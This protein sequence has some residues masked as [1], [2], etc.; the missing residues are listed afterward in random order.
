[1]YPRLLYAFLDVVCYVTNNF[2]YE[3]STVK[4]YPTSFRHR[5]NILWNNRRHE[6]ILDDLFQW[7]KFG[8]DKTLNQRV[9]PG[10]VIVFNQIS[11]REFQDEML[12]VN[13][14]TRTF[15]DIFQKSARYSEMCAIWMARDRPVNSAEELIHRYYSYF[16]VVVVPAVPKPPPPSTT[17]KM[18]DQ[19]KA[20]YTEIK[21]MSCNVHRLRADKNMNIDAACF[22]SYLEEAISTLAR[23]SRSAID[24]SRMAEG[25]DTNLPRDLSDHVSLI[26]RALVKSAT[27]EGS[28]DSAVEASVI[29]NAAPYIACCIK[30]QVSRGNTSSLL[31]FNTKAS[32]EGNQV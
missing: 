31:L 13:G 16:K 23:D 21:A 25:K 22:A 18:L 32:P 27:A 20:S 14:Y 11:D 3:C 6:T 4:I 2:K 30:S 24:F 5:A 29:N 19:V 15:L 1:M 17:R 12:D 26:L 28:E 8:H 7:A 9:K 10:L